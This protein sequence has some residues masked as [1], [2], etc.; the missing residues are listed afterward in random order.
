M[1]VTM[2]GSGSFAGSLVN[3]KLIGENI[4]PETSLAL[5]KLPKI[6]EII[7][8]ILEDDKLF[9][10]NVGEYPKGIERNILMGKVL[11]KIEINA[12]LFDIAAEELELEQILISFPE[13]NSIRYIVFG[14]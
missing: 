12:K 9:W 10:K 3:Y 6:K 14:I 11:G 7:L 13:A 5:E 8:Q 2:S 1:G 4:K